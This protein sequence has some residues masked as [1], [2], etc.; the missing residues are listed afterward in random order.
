MEISLPDEKG[1]LQILE[2]H[3]RQMRD[4]KL[5]DADV[6]LDM[7]QGLTKNFSG[8][9]ISG[10]IRGATSF[11]FHRHEPGT[12]VGEENFKVKK[13]DFMK[14]LGD[15]QPAFGVEDELG[16]IVPKGLI[17]FDK[18]VEV[19][20]NLLVFQCFVQLC[21]FLGDIG[22]WEVSYQTSPRIYANIAG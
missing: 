8:A 9:E 18:G 7:L 14:A 4:H 2:I 1:R 15:V 10:L 11:A 13:E 16:Q 6:N 19:S 12:M 20:V 3:T 22:V 5:M 17:L 21:Y